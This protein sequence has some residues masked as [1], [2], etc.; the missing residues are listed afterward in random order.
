MRRRRPLGIGLAILGIV[1]GIVWL[2]VPHLSLPPFSAH[3]IVERRCARCH[4]YHGQG[5]VPGAFPRLAGQRSA[6]LEAS[7]HAYA[8]GARLSGVMQ[9]VAVEL[10]PEEIQAAADYYAS[11]PP[12]RSSLD[13]SSA[14]GERIALQGIPDRDI[15]AC[16]GCHGPADH[17][18][19][20]SYPRLAG[21]DL[22][23]LRT[24]LELFM[25]GHRGGPDQA[26]LMREV[27][28]HRLTRE[29]IEAVS[30]YYA[31]LHTGRRASR[32]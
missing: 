21:Q 15:P 10:E 13:S 32:P 29:A 1:W 2:I 9:P 18:L 3:M 4:G 6:Y 8:D 27:T 7:L 25:A 30:T 19:D 31:S 23:Y 22:R 11:L 20:D 14:E 24:Q 26:E 17:D 16:A 12:M 28:T 5:R